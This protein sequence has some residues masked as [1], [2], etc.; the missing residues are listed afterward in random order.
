MDAYRG[1]GDGV[2]TLVRVD[3]ERDGTGVIGSRSRGEARDGTC[4]S[5][6]GALGHG[7]VCGRGRLGCARDGGVWG[8]GPDG[9]CW[10]IVAEFTAQTLEFDAL[11]AGLGRYIRDGGPRYG[12][13]CIGDNG[14]C[15]G[16]YR[17]AVV[18]REGCG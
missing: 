16:E 3:R 18:G 5:A 8:C 1:K 9:G 12:R 2:Y 13:G 10:E 14:R 4:A 17:A 15:E 6:R 11:P 7:G